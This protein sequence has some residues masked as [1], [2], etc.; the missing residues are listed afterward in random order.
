MDD[1]LN[2][3]QVIM[4]LIIFFVVIPIIIYAVHKKGRR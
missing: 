2:N 4:F 1:S 3:G